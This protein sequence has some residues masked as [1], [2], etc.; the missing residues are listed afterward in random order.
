MNDKILDARHGALALALS[1]IALPATATAPTPQEAWWTGPMLASSGNT[2]PHGHVLFEP[3]LFD[4]SSKSGDYAGSLTY[5]LYGVTDRLTAGLIP[6]F[7]ASHSQGSDFHR[8]A[9]INDLTLSAQYRIHLAQVGDAMPTWSLVVQQSLPTGKFDRLG[10][11]SDR[12]IGSGTFA[13]M[14]GL[15]AQRLDMMANGHLLRTRVNLSYTI[16]HAA[17]MHDRSVYGT[18]DGFRGTA[19]PG[20]FAMADLAF[21]YSVTRNW[22]LAADLFVRRTGAGDVAGEVAGADWSSR[23][24]RQRSAGIAPAIEYNWSASRGVLLGVRRI[25]EGHNVTASWTPAVAFNAYF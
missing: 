10:P 14:V 17:R 3:Y 6:T 21:E 2:L 23:L 7:G 22:V 13:T 15:Y 11:D 12:G 9:G 1:L 16:P 20:D 5:L 24:P 18:P 8:R 4:Q 19:H 25:F